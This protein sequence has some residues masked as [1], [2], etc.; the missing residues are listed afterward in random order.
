MGRVSEKRIKLYSQI[1]VLVLLFVFSCTHGHRLWLC[2][3]VVAPPSL[4]SLTHVAGHVGISVGSAA[5]VAGAFRRGFDDP[6]VAS[7]DHAR[8]FVHAIPAQHVR[9]LQ[10]GDGAGTSASA[11]TAVNND[12]K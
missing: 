9:C 1:V 4:P 8:L 2:S 12:R 10:M 11:T 5:H 3:V 7:H 6:S